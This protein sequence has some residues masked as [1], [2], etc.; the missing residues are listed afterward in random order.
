M[1]ASPNLVLVSLAEHLPETAEVRKLVERGGPLREIVEQA[2]R[3]WKYFSLLDNLATDQRT[4]R[5]CLNIL[6]YEQFLKD[7]EEEDCL[8]MMGALR[9]T[10]NAAEGMAEEEEDEDE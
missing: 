4:G 3:E 2:E 1:S 6:G 5:Q 9:M 10:A 8:R 7:A